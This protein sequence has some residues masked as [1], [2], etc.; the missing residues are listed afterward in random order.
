MELQKQLEDTRQQ[1]QQVSDEIKQKK[2]QT[3]QKLEEEISRKSH[4]ENELKGCRDQQLNTESLQ[5]HIQGLLATEKLHIDEIKK[6]KDENLALRA[7][8]SLKN[9]NIAES[10]KQLVKQKDEMKIKYQD[11]KER[12]DREISALQDDLQRAKK[13][14]DELL[15]EYLKKEEELKTNY[16]FHK[17]SLETNLDEWQNKYVLLERQFATAQSSIEKLQMDNESKSL[18]LN[19]LVQASTRT[20]MEYKEEVKQLQQKLKICRAVGSLQ[21]NGLI[22]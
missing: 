10:L 8:A 3:D 13:R 9:I 18:A 7:D 2:A 22:R 16:D 19:A 11:C 20:E 6:L 17:K 15:L 14:G 1:Q 4:C 5:F 21:L 12:S